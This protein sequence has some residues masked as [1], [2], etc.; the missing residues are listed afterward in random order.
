MFVCFLLS[1][2]SRKL[3]SKTPA[4]GHKVEKLSN[5]DAGTIAYNP[6]KTLRQ[7]TPSWDIPASGKFG[8]LV[9]VGTMAASTK[10]QAAVKIPSATAQL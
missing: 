6:N 1:E 7:L 5:I 10:T 8:D 4:R 3:M 9:W 2:L